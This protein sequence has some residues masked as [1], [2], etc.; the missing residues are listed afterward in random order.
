MVL[1]TGLFRYWPR[2]GTIGVVCLMVIAPILMLILAVRLWPQRHLSN[3][4]SRLFVVPVTY[5]LIPASIPW[6]RMVMISKS[7]P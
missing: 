1:L 7:G 4:H 6:L 2:L 3:L 5:F